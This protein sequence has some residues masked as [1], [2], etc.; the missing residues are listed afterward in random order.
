MA[1][2]F[3][4]CVSL[5]VV[6]VGFFLNFLMSLL[7]RYDPAALDKSVAAPV[8]MEARILSLK[9][10]TM[11]GLPPGLPAARFLLTADLR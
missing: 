9:V 11:V 6:F 7:A 8:A 2:F 10:E 1:N 5:S 4:L 3:Y